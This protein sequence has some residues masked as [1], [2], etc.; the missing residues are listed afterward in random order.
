MTKSGV[1]VTAKACVIALCLCPIATQAR[2][3]DQAEIRALEERF[4]AAFNA[5]DVDAIMKGY[6][7]GNSLLVFDLVP[8]LQYV[9]APA[10]R[11][12]WEEFFTMFKEGPKFEMRDLDIVT[13]QTLAYSHSIQHVSG[14]NGA[15]DLTVRVTD[16]YRK[17]DGQWLIVHEH[18]S[19]PVDLSTGKPDMAGRP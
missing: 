8:P 15:V 5:K 6:V 1:T 18:V 19:L 11:K 17:I 2:A 13:D 4:A 9:G 16:V 3:D 10:Y 7:P 12:N 14:N